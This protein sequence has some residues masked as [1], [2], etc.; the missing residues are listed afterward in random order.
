MNT[1][2]RLGGA[3][4][5]I[6]TIGVTVVTGETPTGPCAPGEV[7]TPPCASQTASSSSMAPGEVPTIPA[8]ESFDALAL[9]ETLLAL[10]F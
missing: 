2:R 6:F 1:L 3:A 5:L 7:N 8:A 10:V 4:V 9:T